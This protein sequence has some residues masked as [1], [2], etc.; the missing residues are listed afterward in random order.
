VV[1]NYQ[2]LVARPRRAMAVRGASGA[3]PRGVPAGDRPKYLVAAA[4]PPVRILHD[5]RFAAETSLDLEDRSRG[6]GLP[7][8]LVAAVADRRA[9]SRTRDWKSCR[10][11]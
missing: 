2:T 8:G 4:G 1:T 5:V 3:L 6:R 10:L 11:L 9:K 7:V